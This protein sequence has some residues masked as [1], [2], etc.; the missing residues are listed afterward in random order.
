MVNKLYISLLDFISK[1][2]LIRENKQPNK[3]MKKKK[4]IK[5]KNKRMNKKWKKINKI[6]CQIII[7]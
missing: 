2:I 4:K 1:K 3:R 5:N 6:K 7:A